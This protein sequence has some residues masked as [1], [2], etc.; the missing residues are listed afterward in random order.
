[1][2]KTITL[3]VLA[4]FVNI[5]HL[6]GQQPYMSAPEGFGAA[7]TGG[8]NA[9]P[10]T[11]STYADLK[12]AL[13]ASGPAVILVSGTIDFTTLGMMHVVAVDKT[14]IGLPGA[15]F[16]NSNQTTSGI[17]Y[18]ST[19]SS[20]VILRNLIFKGPGAWDNNGND[21]L[22]VKSCTKLWVDHCEF[23]DGEDGNFDNSAVTDNVTV[24]WCKFSYLI[25][26]RPVGSGSGTTADHRFSDLIGGSSTDAPADKHYSITW[27]NCWWSEGC[28]ERMP[29]ARNAELHILNCY[30]YTST[31]KSLALGIGGGVDSSTCYV[32]NSDFAKVA[33]VFKDYSSSDGG[34][35]KLTFSSCLNGGT[36]TSK[37]AP[38]PSY[39][40][41]TYPASDVAAAVT[42]PYCGA[43]ATLIVTPNG[44]ISASCFPLDIASSTVSSSSTLVYPNPSTGSFT[45]KGKEAMKSIS[46]SSMSAE[47]VYSNSNIQTGNELE[48]QGDFEQGVYLIK[49]QN[50]SGSVEVIKFVKTK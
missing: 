11:V 18:L 15:T 48:I 4:L 28:V 12:T 21:N 16:T 47:V 33:T 37:P 34:T 19:G 29:R 26:P 39:S 7:T 49:I 46:I 31:T 43:G 20:N 1:M 2:K 41:T 38:K 45:V 44:A 6:L 32:E 3:F 8:G 5:S 35:V 14:L 23:Q 30:Y 42:N 40:Y 13:T 10:I 36:S 22:T 9:S 17:L 25:A 27:Q 24:S 50:L